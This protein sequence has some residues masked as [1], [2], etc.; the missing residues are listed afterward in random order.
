LSNAQDFFERLIGLKEADNPGNRSQDAGFLAAWNQARWRRFR[1]K[2]TI[3]RA[4]GV[5]LKGAQLPII[6]QD[7]S[8]N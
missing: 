3:T 7:G 1:K 4:A 2:T 8:R 6:A 5:G